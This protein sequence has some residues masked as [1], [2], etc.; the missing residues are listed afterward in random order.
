L[1]NSIHTSI[2]ITIQSELGL[3]FRTK[4]E[5]TIDSTSEVRVIDRFSKPLHK[6]T[7]S[8]LFPSVGTFFVVLQ[9]QLTL[10]KTLNLPTNIS[11]IF[12]TV[13]LMLIVLTDKNL[14][15]ML[16]EALNTQKTKIRDIKDDGPP[17]LLLCS[18]YVLFHKELVFSS[19]VVTPPS[20]ANT[21][22]LTS[23]LF[24]LFYLL[25]L[26]GRSSAC[27]GWLKC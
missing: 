20:L 12:H 9:V 25:H 2:Y 4:C 23:S 26:G 18:T 11:Q 3:R 15:L 13:L 1:T 16:Y 17:S 5:K 7:S 10:Y 8:C 21:G 22:S 19:S 24:Y 27:D 6:L 14:Q